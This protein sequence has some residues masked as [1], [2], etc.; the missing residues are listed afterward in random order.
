MSQSQIRILPGKVNSLYF[1]YVINATPMRRHPAY[2]FCYIVVNLYFLSTC[3]IGYNI[4]NVLSFQVGNFLFM[5]LLP[6]STIAL[7]NFFIFK[8]LKRLAS[9][10]GS[11]QKKSV[12]I[13]HT[14]L[15]PSLQSVEI[16]SHSVVINGQKTAKM[17]AT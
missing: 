17:R 6:F 16:S 15:T 8:I 5:N 2:S 10:K 3:E 12:K 14:F 4:V 9:T 1:Q 7:L 11:L 13:F